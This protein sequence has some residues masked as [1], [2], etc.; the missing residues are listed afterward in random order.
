MLTAQV[1]F[2]APKSKTKTIRLDEIK[3]EGQIQ[4]PQASYILQRSGKVDL[5]VDVRSLKPVMTGGYKEML[6]R[7]PELFRTDRR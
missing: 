3:I 2:A 6:D 5:G 4:K 1:V 7:E